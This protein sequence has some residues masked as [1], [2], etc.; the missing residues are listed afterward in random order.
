MP[1]ITNYTNGGAKG[2]GLIGILVAVVI[3]AI[4]SYG[5]L[6]FYK[7]KKAKD[8][9]KN[10]YDKAEKDINEI[11]KKAD[12]MN[13]LLIETMK[14]QEETKNATGSNE[15]EQEKVENDLNIYPE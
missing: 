6:F 15:N 1:R 12:E 10:A 13:K 14:N 5:G 11:N 3:I 2:F 7:E 8:I 4:L 9:Y